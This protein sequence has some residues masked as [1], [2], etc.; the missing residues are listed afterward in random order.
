M[1][2]PIKLRQQIAKMEKKAAELREQMVAYGIT[3]D[4]LSCLAA[5]APKPRQHL[6]KPASRLKDKKPVV[7][8]AMKYHR[9]KSQE[10]IGRETVP[11]WLKDLLGKE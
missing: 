10:W 4:E 5:K 2:V 6:D 7:P 1:N 8:L 9:L 11:G 3:G